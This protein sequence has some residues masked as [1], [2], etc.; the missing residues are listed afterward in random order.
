M[1]DEGTESVEALARQAAEGDEAAFDRLV[2]RIHPRLMRWALVKTTQADDAEEVV[3]RTLV[4]VYRALPGFRGESRVTTW[5]YRIASN[6]WL[7]MER[8][9]K[10]RSRVEEPLMEDIEHAA[11]ATTPAP[12]ARVA[13]SQEADLLLRFFDDLTVRQRE[14]LE[15]VDLQGLEPAEAAAAMEVTPST[16]RVHLHRARRTLRRIILDREPE[17]A[18][19]YGT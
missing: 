7:D 3:Q 4:R 12:D 16:A 10:S 5:M 18:E 1:R 17:L 6:V 9:R 15:L 8:A 2:R 13:R 14:V 11:V 19:E